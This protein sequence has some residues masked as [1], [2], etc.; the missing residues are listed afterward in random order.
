LTTLRSMLWNVDRVP[1]LRR[2]FFH[3]SLFGF[4]QVDRCYLNLVR[5]VQLDFHPEL[6]LISLLSSGVLRRRFLCLPRIPGEGPPNLPLN[7]ILLFLYSVFC[8]LNGWRSSRS[9]DREGDGRNSYSPQ[10]SLYGF[11]VGNGGFFVHQGNPRSVTGTIL[12]S[13]PP[14]LSSCR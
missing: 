12:R 6:T 11:D 5:P 2:H 9:S 14:F 10:F 8:N 4:Y 3:I 1:E 7:C 13:L